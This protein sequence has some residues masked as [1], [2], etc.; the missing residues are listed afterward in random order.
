VKPAVAKIGW[1]RFCSKDCK[2][3][4]VDAFA[5][6]ERHV[7]RSGDCHIWLGVVSGD[8]GYGKLTID[9]K[10]YSVPRLVLEKKL[11]RPIRPGCMA[12]H[13][14]SAN[15]PVDDVSYRRCIN[16]N[17]LYEGTPADN[18]RDRVEQGRARGRPRRE[19]TAA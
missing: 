13:T 6:I 3:A 12:C 11:G 1:G 9:K 10:S 7:D 2:Y 19:R 14:C 17:H 5:R 18:S 16:P 15:Y 4:P 8:G